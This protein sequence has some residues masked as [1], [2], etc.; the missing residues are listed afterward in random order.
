MDVVTPRDL[1]GQRS[2]LGVSTESLHRNHG[3][4]RTT[5]RDM[6]IMHRFVR[7]SVRR[8]VR[9]DD[10]KP[11]LTVSHIVSAVSALERWIWSQTGSQTSIETLTPEE[12]D[13]HLVTF[14]PNLRKPDGTEYE[15]AHLCKCRSYIERF[16]REVCYP[17]SITRSPMFA[18]SHQAFNVTRTRL[19][20]KQL[21][22]HDG[23]PK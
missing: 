5:Q 4:R 6:V 17:V 14:F 23:V 1:S 13:G 12:L 22:K 21:A 8:R 3:G 2:S 10:G 7:E 9:K 19:R 15:W 18:L 16:L 20:E 11:S